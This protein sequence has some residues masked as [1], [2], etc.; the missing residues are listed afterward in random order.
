MLKN[1]SELLL[2]NQS[3][4]NDFLINDFI[5]KGLDLHFFAQKRETIG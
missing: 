2:Q 1:G 3:K 4:W 5:K